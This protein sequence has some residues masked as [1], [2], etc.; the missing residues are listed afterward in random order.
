[1][2]STKDLMAKS[3]RALQTGP[4]WHGPS[5]EDLLK[6]ISAEEAAAHPYE[7]QHSI[8]ELV[9]HLTAWRQFATHRLQGK[10]DYEVPINS[11][12]DWPPV[13]DL[14]PAAWANA[15]DELKL[16]G[17]QLVAALLSSPVDILEQDVFGKSY[18]Y[19]VLVLG[20]L[21]HDAYHEGQ[22]AMLKRA[23]RKASTSAPI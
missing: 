13:S 14:S 8:W 5:L 9:L 18:P 19:Y 2:A 1:M 3:F 23:L 10:H 21:Q 11:E 6:D 15:R 20:L 17:E 7:G 22:I 4:A 12:L 16:R